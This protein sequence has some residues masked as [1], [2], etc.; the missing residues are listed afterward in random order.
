MYVCLLVIMPRYACASEVC[1]SVL[2][3]WLGSFSCICS[4]RLKSN[5]CYL[6]LEYKKYKVYALDSSQFMLSLE[7]SM[8]VLLLVTVQR[9]IE[10]TQL[11]YSMQ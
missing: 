6:L 4:L 9:N 11:Y 1:S 10:C 2:V 8:A 7:T 5:C 3:C